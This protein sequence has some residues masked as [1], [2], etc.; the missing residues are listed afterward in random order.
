[1][2]FKRAA[3]KNR[4]GKHHWSFV[5]ESTSTVLGL[6]WLSSVPMQGSKWASVNATYVHLGKTV[7]VNK[8]QNPLKEE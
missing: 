1:M 8:S 5:I 3:K 6:V 7:Y 2:L 4:L